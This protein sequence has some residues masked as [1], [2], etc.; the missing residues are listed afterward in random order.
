VA[1]FFADQPHDYLPAKVTTVAVDVRGGTVAWR[2]PNLS[3]S[4]IPGWAADADRFY[5]FSPRNAQVSAWAWHTG[6]RLWT[7]PAATLDQGLVAGDG[8]VVWVAPHAEVVAADGAIGGQRWHHAFAPEEHWTPMAMALGRVY[9]F[10]LGERAGACFGTVVALDAGT[11]ALVRERV[12]N[13]HLG[14]QYVFDYLR[15]APGAELFYGQDGIEGAGVHERE[16]HVIGPTLRPVW[17]RPG[18]MDCAAAGRVLVCGAYERL[19]AG[20]YARTGVIGLDLAAGRVLWTRD[21][22]SDRGDEVAGEWNG[23]VI[24]MRRQAP[25]A[26]SSAGALL[27]LRPQDGQTLWSL[28]LPVA[29][30]RAYGGLLVAALEPRGQPAR[31][32]AYGLP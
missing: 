18:V 6:K 22:R 9:T 23:A 31:A 27:A 25:G 32:E 2:N 13:P 21:A 30:A 17:E 11:G 12:V 1:L 10:G 16:V 4:E 5:L 3:P 7:A 14:C 15:W 28:A 26:A 29:D 24:V 8:L 19:A 20:P